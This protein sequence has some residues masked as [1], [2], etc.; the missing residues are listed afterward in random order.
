[1]GLLVG[2]GP[3]YAGG[4]GGNAG[5]SIFDL[6][7][8]ET[9]AK[10]KVTD[11]YIAEFPDVDTSMITDFSSFFKDCHM[12]EYI[13]NLKTSKSQLFDYTF[14]GC[15][16]LKEIPMIDTSNAT[17]MTATFYNCAVIKA[18]PQLGTSKVTS[19]SQLCY[20]CTSLESVPALD[21]SEVRSGS[22]AFS[23]CTN[24]KSV[25]P[26]SVG[27]MNS[28]SS[29]FRNCYALENCYLIGLKTGISFEFSSKLTKESVLY[30]FENAQTVTASQTITLHADVF[31]QL[32]EDEIAIATEKGFSV[33]SA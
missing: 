4:G 3:A 1:M 17:G 20:G 14:Y 18:I 28:A 8:V 12:L 9:T 16:K 2:L 29:M 10:G 30:I 7:F 24:L 22:N 25:G 33:V 31:G 11:A 13:P 19:I 15:L 21:F 6:D 5:K 26:L 27:I 23:G 32:S